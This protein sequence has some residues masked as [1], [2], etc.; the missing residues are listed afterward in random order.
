MSM[1]DMTLHKIY[2]C[3]TTA[4]LVFFIQTQFSE[5]NQMLLINC[6]CHLYFNKSNT[7][8]IFICEDCH[9]FFEERYFERFSFDELRKCLIKKF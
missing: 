2:L 9:I 4:V 3:E 6:E 8:L 1:L 5:F 7:E